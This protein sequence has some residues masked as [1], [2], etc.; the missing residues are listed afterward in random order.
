MAD[1]NQPRQIPPN[2]IHW[3]SHTSG[4]RFS[5]ETELTFPEGAWSDNTATVDAV[6]ANDRKYQ[7]L[8]EGTYWT[9]IPLDSETQLRVGEVVTVVGREGNELIIRPSE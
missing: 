9:A 1:P 6:L 7:V 8:F 4:D 5:A 3:K 2:H